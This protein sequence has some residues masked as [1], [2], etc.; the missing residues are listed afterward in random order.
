MPGPQ[1]RLHLPFAEW[2]EADKVMWQ[3]ELDDD[4][5]F[6]D[7]IAAR[8]AERTLHKYWMGWRRFLG[9]LTITE[10]EALEIAPP[11]RLTA[12]RVRRFAKHLAET[13]TPHS[14]AIQMESLYGAARTMMPTSGL[15]V[16]AGY[17]DSALLRSSTTKLD[18]TGH[19]KRATRRPRRRADGGEQ[20][21]RT[22][23]N[24]LE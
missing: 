3:S 18:Q 7:G 19:H 20:D 10:P 6:S 11:E 1:P 9:F 17:Q 4:D 23:A 14:V 8:L 5:P 22:S 12:E 24:R 13:N 16:A 21:R 2:P 15:D